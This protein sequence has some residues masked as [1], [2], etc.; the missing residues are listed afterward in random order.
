M[1]GFH[2][3]GDTRPIAQVR[4]QIT[5]SMVAT[6]AITTAVAQQRVVTLDIHDGTA[7]GAEHSRREHVDAQAALDLHKEL[8][9]RYGEAQYDGRHSGEEVTSA[10]WCLRQQLGTVGRTIAAYLKIRVQCVHIQA[11]G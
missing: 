6:R 5:E 4:K 11:T 7:G 1:Q 2:L 9:R 3:G 10:G 8:V